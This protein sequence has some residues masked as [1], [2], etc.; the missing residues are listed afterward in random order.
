MESQIRAKVAK[1][2]DSYAASQKENG[3]KAKNTAG[4]KAVGLGML[5]AIAAAERR[6]AE[7]REYNMNIGKRVNR[8][9]GIGFIFLAC[10]ILVVF[11]EMM[12][13]F[14]EDYV[15]VLEY[16]A[17]GTDFEAAVSRYVLFAATIKRP[18]TMRSGTR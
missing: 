4:L 1:T 6:D 9:S 7:A 3:N 13:L 8:Y 12:F 18:F 14:P 16:G 15:T 11:A 10:P 5:E 2:L 17:Q